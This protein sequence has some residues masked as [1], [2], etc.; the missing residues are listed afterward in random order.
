MDPLNLNP[1]TTALILIDLQ[2]GIAS[3]PTAPHAAGFVVANAA[4]LAAQFRRAGATVVYVRVDLA[5][6]LELPVDAPLP[7]AS[8][9]R[10]MS[11]PDA[12]A[13]E[14]VAEA[15]YQAGDLLITKRQWGAFFGTDLEAQ[16]RQRGIH[17]IVL[18]GIATNFGVESTA[19]AA[20]GLGFALI[21]VE[22]ATTGRDGQMHEFAFTRI[23]PHIARV[24]T[25]DQVIAACV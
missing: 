7:P 18:G 4:R 21:I 8:G 25:T 1:K 24:R 11:P 3:R 2:Q 5:N 14:L 23:F 15:G 20:A 10:G 9:P 13:S 6:R 12:G 22:D 17:T 16:L 19:R